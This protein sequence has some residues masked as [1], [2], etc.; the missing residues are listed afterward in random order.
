MKVFS[1]TSRII[2]TPEKLWSILV[3]SSLYPLWDPGVIRIEGQIAAG[4]RIVAYNRINPKRAFPARV[5]GFVVGERMTWTGGMPLGLF[6]GVR[7][8]SLRPNSD[9][10]VD[11]TLHEAFS[12]PLLP[13][14][15]S[16]IPDM[17]TSFQDAVAGMKRYAERN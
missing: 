9:G 14:I 13:L 7:T 8:F 15:G 17:T 6:K 4:N 3:D 2:S 10:S 11:F 1:A 12:G 16:T 5:T